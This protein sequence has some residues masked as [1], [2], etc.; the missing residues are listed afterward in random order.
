MYLVTQSCPTLCDLMDCSPPGTSAHG[1]L[2]ARILEWVAMPSSRGFS[3][4]GIEPKSLALWEDSLP[5]E[6]PRKPKNTGVGSLSN[7]GFQL[8]SPALQADSLP[9]EPSGSPISGLH[10]L[11]LICLIGWLLTAI[12]LN[13]LL[14]LCKVILTC[15]HF[16][17]VET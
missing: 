3:Q 17:E 7:P 12:T 16:P 8:G 11:I 10:S 5:S 6:P 9:A 13:C 14:S 2:Q 4:P 1:I 15:I